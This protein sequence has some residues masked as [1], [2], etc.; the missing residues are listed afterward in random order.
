MKTITLPKGDRSLS[1][2]FSFLSSLSPQY[3][4]V[5]E[6]KRQQKRRS[7]DQNA[8]LWSLYADM[9]EQCG[10]DL[11]GW[12][13]EDLHEFMLGTHFGWERIEGFGMKRM[14]PLKR[15]S[16]LSTVEFSAYVEFILQFAAEHGVYLESP[17]EVAA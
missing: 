7:T 2:L 9:L 10:E 5:I 15:S 6:V 1:A 17:H 11:R 4:W 3:A 14:R 8:L 12:T 16:K 13:K